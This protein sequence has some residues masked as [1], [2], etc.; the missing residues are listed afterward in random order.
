MAVDLGVHLPLADLGEGV[1]SREQLR[2]Y[3]STAAALGFR[4]VSANDHLVWGRAWL[5]GPTTLA[6]VLDA[7]NGMTLATSIALPAVRHPVVLAK[8]L[9]SLALLADG[10]VIAGLGPGSSAADYD[11]V[12]VDFEERWRRFDEALPLVRALLR[13]EPAPPGAFYRLE[14][15]RLDPLPATPPQVWFGSWGSD[16]RLRRMAAAAEGWLASAYNT[17]PERFA[18]ARARLDGHLVAAGRDPRTFPD[19]VAT[20]WTYVTPDA[21]DAQDLLE[22]FLAPLLRKDPRQLATQ[23]PVGTPEH[24]IELLDAY[25]AAGAR[26]VL[27]W[28]VRSPIRQLETIAEQVVPHLRAPTVGREP[29]IPAS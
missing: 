1:P 11:A 20:A 8:A 19:M 9:A 29:T 16:R 14:R 21:G 5:D 22:G 18:D 13:G 17:T 25:A 6:S 15:L 23:L 4:T 28:P 27:L 3:T 12:G 24:C 10:P 2:T 7:A 26:Q